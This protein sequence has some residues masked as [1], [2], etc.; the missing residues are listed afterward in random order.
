MSV[1]GGW[2]VAGSKHGYDGKAI[3]QR[4]FV[5]KFLFILR[6]ATFSGNGMRRCAEG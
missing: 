1:G 4:A 6:C 3:S 5:V 2:L